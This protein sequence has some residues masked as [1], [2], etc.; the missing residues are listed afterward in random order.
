MAK[1][2]I[3]TIDEETCRAICETG[4]SNIDQNFLVKDIPA[5][6]K[7]IFNRVL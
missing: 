2:V 7:D 3:E 5:L 6:I 1:I 4:K